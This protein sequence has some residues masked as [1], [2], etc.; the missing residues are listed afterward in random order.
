MT[1][2]VV[3]HDLALLVTHRAVLLFLAA[4][5]HD[6]ERFEQIA[7]VDKGAAV[8]HRVDSRLIDNI[9]EVG[10]YQSRGCQGDR[11]Q[12]HRFVHLYIL[13]V[14]AQ[15]FQAALLVGL[16][17]DNPAVKAPRTQQRLIK[18]LGPVGRRQYEQSL[19]CIKAVHLR[20]EL[21]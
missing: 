16:I 19:G 21:V 10:A 14:H 20:K 13:G 12:I 8:L 3:C 5:C 1:H 18:H 17:Y 7:L 9:G 2:L 4:H 6:L 11:L 15:R